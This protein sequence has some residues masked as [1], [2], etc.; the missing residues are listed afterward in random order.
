MNHYYNA[1]YYKG[2]IDHLEVFSLTLKLNG[3]WG[4]D[5]GT[6]W[7]PLK[8]VKRADVISFKADDFIKYFGY[9]SLRECLDKNSV[10]VEVREW[11]ENV[12]VINF[13]NFE[14]E[15]G[16]GGEGYWFDRNMK[17]IIYCSHENSITFGGEDLIK[18]IKENWKEWN[19][20][21][22]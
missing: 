22:W 6:Y 10:I 13:E 16:N 8:P 9:V 2:I 7:F 15:Y 19:Q 4:I 18:R 14:P 3:T 20:H 21:I 12:F 1:E 17:W 11:S 5:I